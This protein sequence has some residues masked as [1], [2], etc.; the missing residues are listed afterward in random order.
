[1]NTGDTNCPE[2]DE[3]H[4]R[5]SPEN[6]QQGRPTEGRQFRRQLTPDEQAEVDAVARYRGREWADSHVD[7]ILDQARFIGNL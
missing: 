2:P 5:Q 7:L 4:G 6:D 1:M 3:R